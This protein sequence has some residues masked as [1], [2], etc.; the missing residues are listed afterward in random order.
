MKKTF[1]LKKIIGF[2]ALA[3][4]ALTVFGF[5]VMSLWN[6]VLTAVLAV[7]VI[8]FWQ[9]LGI[10]LLAK[11]LFGNFRGGGGWAG[12]RRA[13]GQKM[14]EKWQQ[15]TPE[16]Q[17]NLKEEWRNKC[18]RWSNRRTGGQTPTNV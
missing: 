9:A 11:I 8:T 18:S 12:K 6:S 15:M 3:A 13:W 16:E 10:F 7:P 14:Q 2:L 1:W 17:E 5:V 4:L